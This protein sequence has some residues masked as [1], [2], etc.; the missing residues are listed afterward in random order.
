[1]EVYLQGMGV[2][3]GIAIAPVLH[4]SRSAFE[5]PKHA[6]TD[7][8][9]ELARLDRAVSKVRHELNEI[10][11]KTLDAVGEAHADIFRVHLMI[12]ED[13]A[14]RD[15]LAAQMEEEKLNVEFILDSIAKR[16]TEMMNNI[17]DQRFRE[18]TADLL[19]VVDRLQRHLLGSNRPM[20]RQIPKPSILVARDLT[21][22]DTATLDLDK[23]LGMLVE[24]GSPTSHSAIL[25]RALE[26]PA[27][28]GISISN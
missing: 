20:L 1:M 24:T 21:P 26:I 22:S 3:P 23:A 16:Y 7:V 14:L 8:S 6:I 2:S 11:Q 28:I 13:V 9:G 27:V 19:D 25:A 12:L 17:Q 15:D 10:Y 5:I 4:Y 18:R